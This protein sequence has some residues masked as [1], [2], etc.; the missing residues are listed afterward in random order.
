LL[1]PPGPSLVLGAFVAF[2]GPLDLLTRYARRSLPT[3]FSTPH[4]PADG[5]G[6]VATELFGR[7]GDLA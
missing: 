4:V 3:D 7:L 2:A 6:A 1:P 5:A